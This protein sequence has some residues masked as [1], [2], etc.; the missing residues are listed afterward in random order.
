MSLTA[1]AKYLRYVIVHKWFVMLACFEMGLYWR[2]IV[3]D[4]SKFLPSEWFP[5][6]AFFYG[7]D[8]IQ[9]GGG[10][11][12]EVKAAFNYA[13]LLHQHRNDHHWQF[14]VLREDDGDTR[15]IQM[16]G[17]PRLEM[18]ADWK[19]ASRAITGDGSWA[20]VRAWW[21]RQDQRLHPWTEDDVLKFLANRTDP[22]W[23]GADE[24]D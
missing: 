7:P 18:L 6:V 10:P 11:T 3:H 22:Y 24:G 17:R 12:V 1:H 4:A 15:A 23:P 9:R 19:G 16:P 21:E 20:A 2:G 8:G 13:W 14:W 5:Y